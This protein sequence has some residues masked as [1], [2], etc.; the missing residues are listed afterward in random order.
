MENLYAQE[1]IEQK[2]AEIQSKFGESIR[3]LLHEVNRTKLNGKGKVSAAPAVDQN[4]I[5]W[6]L[7]WKASAPGGVR[8][9]RGIVSYELN[10]IASVE[11]DGHQ[12]RVS[13]VWVHRRASTPMEFDGHTPTTR[14]RRLAQ[15]SLPDIR[16]AIEAEW[17]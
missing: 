13:R 8:K 11:D 14:M 7:A 16:A 3:N 15:L 10:V 6:T 12:A 1:R 2:I 5:R 9:R 4:T 17:G